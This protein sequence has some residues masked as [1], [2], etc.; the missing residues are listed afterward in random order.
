MMHAVL[1]FLLILFLTP[2]GCVVGLA[3]MRPLLEAAVLIAFI[4]AVLALVGAFA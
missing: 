4:T 1:T 2:I 3:V